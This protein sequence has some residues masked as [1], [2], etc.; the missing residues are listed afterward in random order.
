MGVLRQE[1]LGSFDVAIVGAGPI[2]AA[3]AYEVAGRGAEVA[4]LEATAS[5]GSEC[6]D[7]SAGWVCPSFAGPFVRR[8]ELLAATRWLARPDSPLAIRASPRLLPWLWTLLRRSDPRRVEEVARILGDLATAS[9][10]LHR[11]LT[12]EGVDTGWRASGLL[13]V[14]SNR[15]DYEAGCAHAAAQGEAGLR[16]EP[17]DPGQIPSLP[18]AAAPPA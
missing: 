3:C 5:W 7:A 13:D 14:Y 2:G 16:A 17:V 12:Q 18:A 1:D 10:Q 4:V 6:A 8:S 11:A 9:A 15:R